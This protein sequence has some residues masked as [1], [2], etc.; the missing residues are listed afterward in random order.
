MTSANVKNE[1]NSLLI[2]NLQDLVE[3]QRKEI[4]RLKNEVD[5]FKK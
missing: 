2:K 4:D 5:N 1:E 3:L